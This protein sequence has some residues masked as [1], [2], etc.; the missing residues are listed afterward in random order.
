MGCLGLD[1]DLLERLPSLLDH[2]N[3]RAGSHIPGTRARHKTILG[4]LRK[5]GPKLQQL[6][7]TPSDLRVLLLH[8]FC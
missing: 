7:S 6:G 3:M 1:S 4:C 8:R 5:L 2:V